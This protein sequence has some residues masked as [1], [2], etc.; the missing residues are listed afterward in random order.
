MSQLFCNIL[1]S[2]SNI[3]HIALTVPDTTV[4]S[5]TLKTKKNRKLVAMILK[6]SMEDKTGSNKLMQDAVTKIMIY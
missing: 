5:T 6:H 3:E 4:H 2:L 1:F